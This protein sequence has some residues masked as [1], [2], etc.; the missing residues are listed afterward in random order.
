[1]NGVIGMTELALTTPLDSR[2]R[3][4]LEVVRQSADSL[5]RLLNDVLD[6]SK[7]EAG[8]L[9]LEKIEFHL[10]SLV[11]GTLQVAAGM[12]AEKQI[13]LIHHVEPGIPA[14]MIGDPGRLRQICMNLIGNAIKF[15]Q[16]GEIVVNV[17]TRRRRN[18]QITLEFSVEDTGIGIPVDKMDCIFESFRQAD[19]STTRR[20]GGTGLGLSI[21]SQLVRLMDGQIWVESELGRGS[22]FH[23]TAKFELPDT[24]PAE[25]EVPPDCH[26]KVLLFDQHYRRRAVHERWLH[27]AGAHVELADSHAETLTEVVRAETRVKPF[28]A[29]VIDGASHHGAGWTIVN[30]VRDRPELDSCAI[31][32]LVPAIPD[33]EAQHCLGLPNVYGLTKPVSEEQLHEALRST[34]VPIPPAP[35]PVTIEQSCGSPLSILLAEDG[36]VNQMVALGLLELKGYKVDVVDDGQAA[37]EACTRRHYDVVLMD[38]EMPVMDGIEATRAIRQHQATRQETPAVIIAMTAHAVSGFEQRCR[39]AG[40]DDFLTKPIQPAQLYAAL[41][42]VAA[43]VPVP[44]QPTSH[45]DG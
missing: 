24:A 13:E 6:V 33:A 40:M 7:I 2:Q 10:P 27:A 11:S 14:V 8:K 20:F 17:T 39:E 26:A 16:Q 37:V 28:N 4:Y 22:T 41:E 15:T 30:A 18:K 38:V 44:A 5:L 31:L 42:R 21:S 12:A 43:A 36:N 32:L 29:L 23:F 34:L 35:R 3:G 19:S 1:M 9:E 45:S 25:H